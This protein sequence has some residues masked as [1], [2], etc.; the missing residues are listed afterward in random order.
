MWQQEKY[1]EALLRIG[2]DQDRKDFNSFESLH[3]KRG[4]ECPAPTGQLGELFSWFQLLIYSE[5]AAAVVQGRW[6][7]AWA[8]GGP[9][10]VHMIPGFS[11][12]KNVRAKG[13]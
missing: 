4:L 13:L 2:W 9:H 6:T 8:G 7:T 10:I 12:M 5:V 3:E 1:L 11:G